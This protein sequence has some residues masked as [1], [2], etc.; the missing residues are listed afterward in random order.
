MKSSSCLLLV[1]YLGLLLVICVGQTLTIYVDLHLRVGTG[2]QK[3]LFSPNLDFNN[4]PLMRIISG[5]FKENKFHILRFILILGQ[6][7]LISDRS[8]L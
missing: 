6:L 3:N 7:L 5:L 4:F 2:N 8:R 1:F